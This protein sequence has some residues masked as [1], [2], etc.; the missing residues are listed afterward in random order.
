MFR[1]IGRVWPGNPVRK[2]NMILCIS[3]AE[4]YLENKSSGGLIKTGGCPI[5]TRHQTQGP[6]DHDI[7]AAGPMNF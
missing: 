2:Y 5:E 4:I 1:C 3:P 7:T 6:S